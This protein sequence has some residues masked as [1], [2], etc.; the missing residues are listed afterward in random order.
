MSSWEGLE[1]N[2]A[3]ELRMM[4][5]RGQPDEVKKL[6]DKLD[7]ES[8]EFKKAVLESRCS[9]DHGKTILLSTISGEKAAYR[10]RETRQTSVIVRY[11]FPV[12][13]EKT[14]ASIADMLIRAG[15]DPLACDDNG[16]DLFTHPRSKMPGVEQMIPLAR[17]SRQKLPPMIKVMEMLYQMTKEDRPL[18]FSMDMLIKQFEKYLEAKKE[19]EKEKAEEAKDEEEKK[20]EE[21]IQAAILEDRRKR[22]CCE[23][24]GHEPKPSKKQK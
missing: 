11:P 2:A 6:L 8:D 17:L 12:D 9:S 14:Y 18:G 15:A 24:R 16:C 10:S 4:V 13:P 5:I 3:A 1:K 23:S 7:G 21:E 20:R 22:G 19:I